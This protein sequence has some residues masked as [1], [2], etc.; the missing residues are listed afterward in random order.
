MVS[1]TAFVR[2]AYRLLNDAAW[3]AYGH[4]RMIYFNLILAEF[5]KQLGQRWPDSRKIPP[6]LTVNGITSAAQAL[7]EK[8]RQKKERSK[9]R[10]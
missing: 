3:Q 4:D 10:K 9:S 6:T 8:T 1:I 2:E 7:F 5:L